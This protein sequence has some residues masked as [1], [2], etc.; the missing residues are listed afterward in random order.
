MRIGEVFGIGKVYNV[1]GDQE[2][3]IKNSWTLHGLIQI[4]HEAL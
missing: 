4:T 1:F 3:T 2:Y